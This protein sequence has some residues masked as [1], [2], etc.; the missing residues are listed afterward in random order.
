MT[1]TLNL[2]S[3]VLITIAWA[4]LL[5]ALF[6]ERRASA[7]YRMQRSVVMQL[8]AVSTKELLADP[9]WARENVREAARLAFS[10]GDSKATLEEMEAVAQQYVTKKKAILASGQ[11]LPRLRDVM[12]ISADAKEWL[13]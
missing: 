11:E 3:V 1:L 13:D 5:V 10:H 4:V 9:M 2:P 6:I 12:P 7:R 8:L